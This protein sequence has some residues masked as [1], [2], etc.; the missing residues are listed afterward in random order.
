MKELCKFG[1]RDTSVVKDTGIAPHLRATETIAM[2]PGPANGGLYGGP[3]SCNYWIPQPVVPTETN[4]I[5]N[6][7][8]KA[9]PTPPPGATTQYVSNIRPGN[10]YVAKVGVKKY[11]NTPKTNCGPF[12]IEGVSS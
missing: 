4:F 8:K 1:L 9:N 10:N 7:L 12:D 2:P 3:Q 5:N 6:L 11:R